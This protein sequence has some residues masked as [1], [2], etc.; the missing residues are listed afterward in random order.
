MASANALKCAS[1]QCVIWARLPPP[2]ERLTSLGCRLRRGS[3]S[4]LYS[5]EKPVPMLAL[6]R[7]HVSRS[8]SLSRS[9]RQSR[10][11]SEFVAS[12]L[13]RRMT[14]LRNLRFAMPS[15]FRRYLC[16]RSATRLDPGRGSYCLGNIA[17]ALRSEDETEQ[18]CI[19]G[20]IQSA[21]LTFYGGGDGMAPRFDFVMGPARCFAP[22][23]VWTRHPQVGNCGAPDSAS[24]FTQVNFRC[25]NK[26]R[27][28]LVTAISNG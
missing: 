18:Q 8:F 1:I 22:E 26:I 19:A 14:L 15:E 16:C 24:M 27:L 3:L 12:R 2:M 9:S 28:R 20:S 21:P 4:W 13:P 7:S 6:H 11:R 23:E 5:A 17:G 25:I 10:N